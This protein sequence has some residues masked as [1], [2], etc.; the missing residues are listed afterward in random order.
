MCPSPKTL[1]FSQYK[2]PRLATLLPAFSNIRA[3]SARAWARGGVSSV[4]SRGSSSNNDCLKCAM[5]KTC[6][7]EADRCDR[8][9]TRTTIRSCEGAAVK[10]SS[11]DSARPCYHGGSLEDKSVSPLGLIHN[12]HKWREI[13][14][15]YIYLV[16][17]VAYIG[18][19]SHRYRLN[20][21]CNCDRHHLH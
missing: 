15:S 2:L 7:E 18:S 17:H 3:F 1:L 19:F 14:P 12:G 21:L 13:A 16:G 8:Q 9:P 20:Y 4:R 10:T 5:K 11:N 6:I